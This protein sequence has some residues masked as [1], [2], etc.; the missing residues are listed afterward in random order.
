MLNVPILERWSVGPTRVPLGPMPAEGR[1]LWLNAAQ[2]A[3]WSRVFG[4]KRIR[5]L[6]PAST[7]AEVQMNRVGGG[8]LIVHA[9]EQV[10][11]IALVVE[12]GEFWRVEEAASVQA[13]YGDEVSP[14][15]AA[16]RK[17][18]GQRWRFRTSRRKW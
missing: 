1:H 5:C 18:G 11:F 16:V 17:I 2:S 7:V 13:A 3:P 8:E 15:L 14:V 9:V 12:H 6:E 10:L 4:V